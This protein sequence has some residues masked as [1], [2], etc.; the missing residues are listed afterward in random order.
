M[1]VDVLRVPAAG[2]RLD[3]YPALAACVARAAARPAFE[4]AMADH[5]DHWRRADAAREA[6]PR[7][8]RE[9]GDAR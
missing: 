7:R 3:D 1:M 9:E 2:G 8:E 4:R 5:M 6:R